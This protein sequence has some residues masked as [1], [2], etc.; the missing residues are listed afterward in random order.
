MT[1]RLDKNKLFEY[2]RIP[3][4][5]L[6]NHPASRI[7]IKIYQESKKVFEH[8][9]QLM[10]DEVVA[11]NQ[12]GKPTRWVM[13]ASPN[14]QFKIFIDYVNRE[15]LSLNNLHIFLMDDYLDWNCRPFP[16]DNP[17]FNLAAK[18]DRIFYDKIDPQLNVPIEKRHHPEYNNL[19]AMDEAVE[20]VGG[21]DTVWGGLGFRGLVAYCEAPLSPWF[22]VTEEEY[23]QMKT[24]ITPINVDTT[25]ATAQRKFGGLTFMNPPMAVTI[26]FKSLL[27]TK[28]VV[29]ISTTGAWKRT[30]VRVLMFNEPTVEYPATLFTDKVE[31]VLLLC[32]KNTAEA[33]LPPL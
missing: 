2:C 22:S 14:E 31:E 15:R 7:K 10:I 33:P 16:R 21:T 12:A 3:V 25:I 29:L 18:F 24:R 20:A 19:D 28:R 8:A 32:D 17:Y 5:Q 11:N 26:G 23:C 4:E 6:E 27:M 9:G 30:A 1:S 13:P